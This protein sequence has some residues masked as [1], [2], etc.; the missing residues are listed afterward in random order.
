MNRGY[1]GVAAISALTGVSQREIRYYVLRGRSMLEHW[2]AELNRPLRAGLPQR[3]KNVGMTDGE[4]LAVLKLLGMIV[5][6]VPL[7]R[8]DKRLVAVLPRLRPTDS[9]LC[10]LSIGQ[11]GHAMVIRG[12]RY[13]DNE[14]GKR[15]AE[16][17]D[18]TISAERWYVDAVWRVKPRFSERERDGHNWGKD[19]GA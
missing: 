16:L 12:T 8:W 5:K 15:G 11:S 6:R 2:A 10:S 19:H 14:T 18:M 13:F 3:I 9:Y 7:P 1:C 4:M 17:R